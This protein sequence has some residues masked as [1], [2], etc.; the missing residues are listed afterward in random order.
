MTTGSHAMH[1]GSTPA[2][3]TQLT[4]SY[5]QTHIGSTTGDYIFDCGN[6]HPTDSSKHHDG[7]LQVVLANPG[8][9]HDLKS[10]NSTTAGYYD[11]SGNLVTEMAYT[12]GVSVPLNG[13][14]R[15]VYCHSNGALDPNNNNAN[16][17]YKNTPTWS[18]GLFASNDKCGQCHD[19]PPQYA[20]QAHYTQSNF[21]GKEGGHLVGI[22]F[23]NI[24]DGSGALATTGVTG[25]SSH[26]N[27]G[28]STTI[29][30]YIC[31][32]GIVSPS[33]IDTYAMN[34]TSSKFKC[35]TCHTGSTTPL[36]S[37]SIIDKSLHVNGVKNVT[38]ANMTVRSKAQLEDSSIPPVWTRNG[39]YKTLGSFDT[40]TM[41]SADWN[42]GSKT[43]TTACHNNLSVTWNATGINCVSCH[44]ALP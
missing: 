14:C 8:P 4:F 1:V 13:S 34:G 22:H 35:S 21:M 5:S 31:H 6:C 25:T 12:W 28:T 2:T 27:S 39:T 19:N 43:C 3:V 16:L 15:G 24:W 42:S 11:A 32:Y 9:G 20:G 17:V 36:Q 41:S 37:G 40:A 29:S 44:T 23:D 7:K 33:T 26:G 30:C 18:V 38:L 10:N